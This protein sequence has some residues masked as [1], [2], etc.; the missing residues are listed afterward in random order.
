[1]LVLQLSQLYHL[2]YY[3]YVWLISFDYY[4]YLWVVINIT[5]IWQIGRRS[6]VFPRPH[7]WQ[8]WDVSRILSVQI[9]CTCHCNL[10][11]CVRLGAPFSGL[12][13]SF[14]SFINTVIHST[15]ILCVDL[16]HM[17]FSYFR[18]KSLW[19]EL[20]VLGLIFLMAGEVLTLTLEPCKNKQNK[21]NK[22]P[23][24][25]WVEGE[26]TAPKRE[27]LKLELK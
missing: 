23:K 18:T 11:C 1:M 16:C 5:L 9:L 19:V 27:P 7:G 25:I 15:W 12:Y 22:S 20:V 2:H 24:L 8:S 17:I 14:I 6:K 21:T 4:R 26:E 3:L 13:S 10:S